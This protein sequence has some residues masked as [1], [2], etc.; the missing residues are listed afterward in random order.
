M[1]IFLDTA[2]LDEIERWLDCGVLDGVTTNPSIMLKDGGY[3]LQRRALEVARLV[4]PRPVSVE[5]TS[6]DLDEMVRQARIYAEWA[7]NI[8]VKIPVINEFGQ[9]C[10]GV[11]RR[12]E[13]E[14]IR[15]NMTACLSYGQALLGAKAGATYVSIFGGRVSD[16]GGDAPGLVRSV[17]DWLDLWG[18]PSKIIVGS[19][20]STIDVQNAA[21][22]GAH[23]ITVPPPILDKFIDHRYSRDTVRGFNED[24]VKALSKMEELEAVAVRARREGS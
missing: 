19:I 6:N 17:R 13:R 1:E 18:S 9:P 12:L 22:A 8:V 16:E 14:R 21:Q 11:V 15:V 7:P 3:D 10:L 20:R 5:V 4:A 2:D 23:V 24:A